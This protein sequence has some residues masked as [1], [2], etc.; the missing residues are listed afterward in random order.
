MS[1]SDNLNPRLF[2]LPEASN[3]VDLTK[4]WGEKRGLWHSSDDARMPLKDRDVPEDQDDYDWSG[5]APHPL[6]IH[7]GSSYAALVRSH[8][9]VMHPVK[10]EGRH[11]S[12]HTYNDDDANGADPE[13]TRAVR[14][15]ENVR[16]ENDFEDEQSVSY[17][18]PVGNVVTWA[19]DV[20][21][22]PGDHSY[23][24][25]RAVRQGAE[26]VYT[27][28]TPY[29][30]NGYSVFDYLGPKSTHELAPGITGRDLDISPQGYEDPDE[31]VDRLIPKLVYPQKQRREK[32]EN[33]DQGKLL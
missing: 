16:Y 23:H 8:G 4:A 18:A 5:T 32:K 24:E 31:R 29:Q 6:G 26:L 12:S 33:P 7:L 2:D 1:A 11:L 15:G 13:L 14:R 9:R 10:L 17:R 30:P 28:E 21:R 3:S 25:R 22:N 19:K 20:V 27:P